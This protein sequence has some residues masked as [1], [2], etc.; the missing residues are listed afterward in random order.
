MTIHNTNTSNRE[1]HRNRRDWVRFSIRL[2]E[3]CGRIVSSPEGETWACVYCET[4]NKIMQQVTAELVTQD[5]SASHKTMATMP[6]DWQAQAHAEHAD[7]LDEKRTQED[8]RL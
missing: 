5:L 6:K 1:P 4:D 3:T 2:C 8:A 7:W